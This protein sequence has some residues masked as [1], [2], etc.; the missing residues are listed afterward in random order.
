MQTSQVVTSQQ[1]LRRLALADERF[2]EDQAGF[3]LGLATISA[4]GAKPAP[5]LQLN[6]PVAIGPP[7][8]CLEWTARRGAGGG[9]EE[10]EIADVLL[11]TA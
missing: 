7:T 8:A 6:A 1:A 2:V 9:R 5:L 4:L 3:G 10:H 11:M